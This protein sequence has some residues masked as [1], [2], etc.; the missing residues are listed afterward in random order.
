MDLFKLLGASRDDAVE[1][2]GADG[3]QAEVA[4]DTDA[5]GPD[6]VPVT[7]TDD[8]RPLLEALRDVIDPEIGIN[9]VD[10]GLV[11]AVERRGECVDVV[12]TMTTPACPLSAVI[13]EDVR[14]ALLNGVAGVEQVCVAVIFEPPWSPEM[15]SERA[16]TQMGG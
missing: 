9:I 1:E 7:A 15:M 4:I 12:L 10:L 8:N 14:D 13:E 2:S 6:D 3:A 11:Y 16:R 5:I